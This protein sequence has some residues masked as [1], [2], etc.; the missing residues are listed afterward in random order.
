MNGPFT[1]DKANG[2]MMGVCAGLADVTGA[3]ATLIRLAAVLSLFV[4][5]PVA[6]IL[7]VVAGCVA[8]ERA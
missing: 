5:G 8:P 6:I 4:L 7:Y 1:L 2:K 3:D